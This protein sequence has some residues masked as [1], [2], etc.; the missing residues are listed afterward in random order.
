MK[1]LVIGAAGKTGRAVVERS[2]KQ[3]HQ[4]TAFIHSEGGYDVPGV[5]VRVGDANDM[6]TMEGAVLGQDAVIDAVG[7]KSPYKRTTLETGVAASVVG[8]MHRHGVRRLVAV[9][10]FGAG[11]SAANAPFYMKMLLATFLRGEVPDK[12]KKESTISGSELDWVIVR[13]PFLTEK[14]ATGDVHV[15]P[16]DSRDKPHSITRSDLA[17]FMVAQLTSDDYLGKAVT[18]AN[19]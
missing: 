2:V 9:S 1:V 3:G 7:G 12:S 5:E 4:V 13:P 8:A 11:D 14:P 18:I 6:A 17:A 19:R 16:A 10:M 15:Y